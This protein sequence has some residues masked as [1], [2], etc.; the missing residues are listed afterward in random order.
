MFILI[1]LLLLPLD[2][3]RLEA[4]R[5]REHRPAVHFVQSLD[6]HRAKSAGRC[7]VR[8]GKAAVRIPARAVKGAAH[9]VANRPHLPAKL[10][11]GLN[12]ARPRL[13]HRC[14]LTPNVEQVAGPFRRKC[15]RG[16]CREVEAMTLA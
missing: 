2:G 5:N 4:F 8:L 7:V 12:Q 13:F 9:V 15:G 1:P 6:G 16:G 3:H 10:L 14:D 11:R